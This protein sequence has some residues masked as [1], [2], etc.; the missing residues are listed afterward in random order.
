M[1]SIPDFVYAA[2]LYKDDAAPA[3][4]PHKDFASER[5]AENGKLIFLFQRADEESGLSVTGEAI[6]INDPI[7]LTVY[8]LSEVRGTVRLKI[9]VPKECSLEIDD[10]ANFGCKKDEDASDTY[11][12]SASGIATGAYP[13][14]FTMKKGSEI[15]HIFSEYINV[16]NGLCTD[17]WNGLG[18]DEAKKIMQNMI[19]STVCVRGAGGYYDN[20]ESYK[21]TATASD[22]N[23]G[24]FLMPLASIQKAID[25]IIT[26]NDGSSAYTI[27]VDGILDG[28]SATT[29]GSEGLADFSALGENLN[30]TIKALSGTATLDGGARFN[31][32]GTVTNAGIEKRVI[33]ASS[34]RYPLNLSSSRAGM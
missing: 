29:L 34:E 21:D 26:I 7:A 6:E 4:P 16:I 25:K 3:N 24:I 8:S 19:S 1:P 32:S 27:Y 22:G 11:T 20:T 2:L 10:T 30:L 18:K 13:L 14:K 12:I 17:T 15:V 23:A 33:Y 5:E 31:E 28:T 9:Q